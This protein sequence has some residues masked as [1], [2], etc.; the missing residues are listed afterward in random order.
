VILVEIIWKWIKS[1]YDLEEDLN[2]CGYDVVIPISYALNRD[3]SLPDATKKTFREAVWQAGRFGIPIIWASSN[4]LFQGSKSIE[5]QAK[6]SFLKSIQSQKIDFIIAGGI[7]NSITEAQSVKKALYSKSIRHKKMIIVCDWP[8][9]RSIQLIWQKVFPESEI[10]I[11]SVDA[12]W[13]NAHG[14][15]FQRSL[16]RWFVACLIRHTALIL[17]GVARLER[18][19][20]AYRR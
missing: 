4:F 12:E 1:L 8:H 17:F 7:T 10:I 5:D 20:Q 2:G 3:K 14:I 11:K 13:N 9:A 19:R 16:F 15:V 18:L 6:K